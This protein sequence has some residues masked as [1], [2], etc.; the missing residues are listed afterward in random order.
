MIVSPLV[1]KPY[2]EGLVH[3]AHQS[4]LLLCIIIQIPSGTTGCKVTI[5]ASR[6]RIDLEMEKLM[7]YSEYA[8]D[9]AMGKFV[10]YPCCWKYIS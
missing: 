1:I 5:P 4:N 10:L 8:I 3:S 6:D 9:Q 2:I 7:V